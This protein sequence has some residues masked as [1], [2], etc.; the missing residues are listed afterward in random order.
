MLKVFHP[1]DGVNIANGIEYLQS[2]TGEGDAIFQSV[3]GVKTQL[4]IMGLTEEDFPTVWIET[5]EG[6]RVPLVEASDPVPIVEIKDGLDL[7]TLS[8]EELRGIQKAWIDQGFALLDDLILVGKFLGKKMNMV[9]EPHSTEYWFW[10]E[11]NIV[12]NLFTSAG[13]YNTRFK[14]YEKNVTVHVYVGKVEVLPQPWRNCD[15]IRVGE[16]M[17]CAISRVIGW[18]TGILI[19]ERNP[20]WG[21]QFVPGRWLDAMTE[22]I[23]KARIANQ[24]DKETKDDKVKKA[25]LKGMLYGEAV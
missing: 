8:I 22:P 18:D 23:A 15:P 20:H 9:N 12:L 7:A 1:T 17:V 25:L 13:S 2:E 14:D 11:G 21:A 19:S 6:E 3:E 4:L 16:H 24:A 5:E 10:N